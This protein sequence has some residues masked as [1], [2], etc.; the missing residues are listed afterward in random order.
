MPAMQEHKD[1]RVQEYSVD[2]STRCGQVKARRKKRGMQVNNYG[3]CGKWC[4]YFLKAGLNSELI[5]KDI[6]KMKKLLS[7]LFNF[8]FV[9]CTWQTA[10]AG[11]TSPPPVQYPDNGHSYQRIVTGMSWSG[12]KTHCEGL[13]GYLATLTSK[14]ENDFVFKNVG[15]DGINIWLGGTDAK[16]E[17]QWEWVTGETWS[18]EN[19]ASG[20]PDDGGT[21][22][23]DQLIF[24]DQAPGQW[25]DNGLPRNDFSTASFICEWNQQQQPSASIPTMSVWGIGILACILGFIGIRRRMK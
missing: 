5:E 14:A 3:L 19:W 9:T 22:G 16:T 17:G 25:D 23:Q 10:F 11:V 7:I 1:F 20:Q 18:Y 2:G 15:L 13:G 4:L 24:W 12:A 6:G 8:L 21:G